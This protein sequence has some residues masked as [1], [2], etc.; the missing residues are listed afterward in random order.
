MSRCGH[1][2]C[3]CVCVTLL[4][5]M[6]RR[7]SSAMIKAKQFEVRILPMRCTFLFLLPLHAQKFQCA[8]LK[9]HQT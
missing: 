8:D 2:S 1:C 9:L 3:V 4:R 7:R 6:Y 5:A